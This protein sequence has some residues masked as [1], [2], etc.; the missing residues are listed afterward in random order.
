LSLKDCCVRFSYDISKR[1]EVKKYM[2]KIVLVL[3]VVFSLLLGATPAYAHVAVKPAQVG[4]AERVTFSVGVP[5]EE[6][7]PTVQVRLVIPEGLQSVTPFVKPGWE[8]EL[9]KTGEGEEAKVTEIIWSGGSIPAERRDEFLFA[10]QAPADETALVWKAYQTY[11]DGD[12]VAWENSPEVIKEYTKNNPPKEGEDDHN[13]P[14]PY[15]ETKVINDLKS[16]PSPATNTQGESTSVAG[17]QNNTTPM[18]LSVVALL[19]AAGA[20]GMQFYKKK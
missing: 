4:A 6:E 10:A 8:I 11:G 1:E 5:T 16:S 12:I 18:M 17:S 13:A 2:K 3:G 14:R 20:L 19:L 7:D 15:S 9:K